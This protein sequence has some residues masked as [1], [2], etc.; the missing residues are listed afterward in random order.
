MRYRH[1]RHDDRDDQPR[2]LQM[3]GNV[4][5]HSEDE[6][7]NHIGESHDR[8]QR[9]EGDPEPS[10]ADIDMTRMIVEAAKP[11]GIVVHDHIIV[12]RQGH[13]SFRSKKL[14]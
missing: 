10:R 5:P 2:T 14:I 4:E 6:V 13:V 7:H 9:S 12:G 3:T 1:E 11:L 8:G